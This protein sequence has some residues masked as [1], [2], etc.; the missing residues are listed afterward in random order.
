MSATRTRPRYEVV[1]R[2]DTV[3]RVISA[4]SRKDVFRSYERIRL[5]HDWNEVNRQAKR[6]LYVFIQQSALT[7]KREVRKA[8][9]SETGGIKRFLVLPDDSP[10]EALPELICGLSVR[11]PLRLHMPRLEAD[12]LRSFVHRFLAALSHCPTDPVIVDAWL[13]GDCLV[14]LSPKLERLKVPTK[15]LPK[16][17]D[18]TREELDRFEIDDEGEFIYWSGH[19]VHMGWS[20]FEQ[21]VKPEKRLKARKS[22]EDF[23]ARYGRAVRQFRREA[24]LRQSDIP[25]L[26]ERT[27]RRIER[28][29]TRITGNALE[30][31]AKAHSI[32]PNRYLNEIAARLDP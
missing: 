2:G 5:I 26:D 18:A 11:S 24:G 6:D 25:G 31:L 22:S 13:E 27:I 21:L 8:K 17:A 15:M 32:D 7:D 9:E 1:L 10:R 4:E 29:L 30:K 12:D 23:N 28:G 3:C 19:D 20:Q 14:V 16:L